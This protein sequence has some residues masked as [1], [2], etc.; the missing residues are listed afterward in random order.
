MLSKND[1]EQ[2]MASQQAV[3]LAQQ[4]LSELYKSENP[5]LSEHAFFLLENLSAINQKLRRLI[6]I[7]Q[8]QPRKKAS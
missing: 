1:S 8:A 2:L 4:S 3:D 7:T 5:L 6:T